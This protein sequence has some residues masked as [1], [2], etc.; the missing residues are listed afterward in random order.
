MNGNSEIGTYV[1]IS[2]LNE[3]TFEKPHE[4]HENNDIEMAN[5]EECVTCAAGTY[6]N[7]TCLTMST[8]PGR[9]R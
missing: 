8:V 2:A 1:G 9:T 7:M 4:I 3:I 6:S 5:F